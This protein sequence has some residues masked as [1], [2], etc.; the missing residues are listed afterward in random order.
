M[1]CGFAVPA[2]VGHERKARGVSLA[3]YVS[4]VKVMIRD[5]PR[6]VGRCVTEL[7]VLDEQVYSEL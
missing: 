6:P 5:R 4:T 2:D 7:Y 3:S 1:V